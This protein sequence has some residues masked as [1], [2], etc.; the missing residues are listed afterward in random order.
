MR[1]RGS[2]SR[3]TDAAWSSPLVQVSARLFDAC[4]VS[5]LRAAAPPAAVPWGHPIL[6]WE[7]RFEA[8]A[9]VHQLPVDSR[10]PHEVS[11]DPRAARVV[12]EH[13]LRMPLQSHEELP[14]LWVVHAGVIES[15]GVGWE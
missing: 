8:A 7:L 13:A 12:L 1:D 5:R 11:V 3:T 14:L 4:S 2:A 15:L 6:H 10:S 9:T